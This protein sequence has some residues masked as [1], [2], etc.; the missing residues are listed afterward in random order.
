MR[1]ACSLRGAEALRWLPRLTW[2]PSGSRMGTFVRRGSPRGPGG[3]PPGRGQC[4][5]CTPC[6]RLRFPITRLQPAALSPQGSSPGDWWGQTQR[7]A[8]G[9]CRGCYS[10]PEI[11][12][13]PWAQE[14]AG[15]LCPLTRW[16][17]KAP[18]T[19]GS[20]RTPTSL[21]PSA[22]RGPRPSPALPSHTRT[23]AHA[24]RTQAFGFWS[25][26]ASLIRSTLTEHGGGP[27][28]APRPVRRPGPRV[29]SR[30][31]KP[32]IQR[33]E[34]SCVCI[35]I[36]VY[37]YVYKT[38]ALCTAC[39]PRCQAARPVLPPSVRQTQ[40]MSPAGR[41]RGGGGPEAVPRMDGDKMPGR[42]KECAPSWDCISRIRIYTR[43]RRRLRVWGCACV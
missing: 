37:K 7:W 29:H 8:G 10:L 43:A 31:Q 36:Y 32:P 26:K 23:R 3:R 13:H 35:Y 1:R 17:R 30:R 12:G 2:G 20:A 34:Y 40:G 41:W 9:R 6:A 14:T 38:T 28:R 27:G 5:W 42:Q 16:G 21:S 25:W 15:S 33:R 18:R 24:V 11:H 4:F 39:G 19:P 22:T